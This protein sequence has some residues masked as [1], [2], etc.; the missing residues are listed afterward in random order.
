MTARTITTDT[1]VALHA[2]SDGAPS[3]P[4]MLL[5]N[6]LGTDL[7]MWDAQVP[8]WSAGHRVLRYDPR[9]HGASDVPA[10]PYTIEQ[11]G[12]DAIEVLDAY[13]VG[14]ADLCGISLGGLVALWLA[15][16]V[17]E[18]VGRIVLADTAGRVGTAEAWR[19]RAAL[20]R[21]QGMAGVVDLVLERFFSPG[22]RTSGAPGLVHVEQ[23]LRT[24]PAE[25]YAASCEALA[26][27]DLRPVAHRITAPC[28]VVV[29]S[30]DAATPPSDAQALRDL[31]P[32]AAY[33]ELPGAGHLANLEQPERFGR[34][35]GQFL[36]SPD[37]E[38]PYA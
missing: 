37:Q 16:N 12:A 9:G 15:V 38:T 18:R 27:T 7:S 29:G 33:A 31:V 28:L 26:V 19:S 2:R 11:F 10:G 22:F 21:E 30:A 17:P 36:S 20:V 13:E 6:S 14:R 4:P 34:L 35:V 5:L 3:A 25:G 23:R 8:A 1:G 24:A 32:R